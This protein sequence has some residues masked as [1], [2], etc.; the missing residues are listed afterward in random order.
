VSLK[1]EKPIPYYPLERITLLDLN[2]KPAVL[3]SRQF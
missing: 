3:G 2:Q 1:L